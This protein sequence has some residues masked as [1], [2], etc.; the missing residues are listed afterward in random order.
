M[1]VGYRMTKPNG[2]LSP[3]YTFYGALFRLRHRVRDAGRVA[4]ISRNHGK[5]WGPERTPLEVFKI[6]RHEAKNAPVG[7]VWQI[8]LGNGNIIHF[9]KVHYNPPVTDT[10]GNDRIDKVYTEMFSK[11]A[12]LENWGICV[13]KDIA[14]TST[15]SQHSYCNALDTHGSQ[16]QMFEISRWLVA[17][18]DNL[19]VNTV[20]FN[21]QAW[22]RAT[23]FWHEY[24]GVNPHTDHVHV[25]CAPP[26][27]GH[28]SACG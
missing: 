11:W 22:S 4:H 2:K 27:S 14:G 24:D 25:D 16:Q 15:I 5:D 12:K 8:K 17:N 1:A 21:R 28:P 10:A 26:G 19:S 6:M 18:Q 9:R 23:P 7:M 13:C 20:I 3:R